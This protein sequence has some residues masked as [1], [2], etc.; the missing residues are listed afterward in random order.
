MIFGN[1]FQTVD[2]KSLNITIKGKKSAKDK[3]TKKIDLSKNGKGGES[4]DEDQPLFQKSK[5]GKK[6]KRLRKEGKET[7]FK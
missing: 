5:N 7:E 1:E 4:S 6:R 2:S 3:E